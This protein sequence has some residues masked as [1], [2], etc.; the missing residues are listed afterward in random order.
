[1]LGDATSQIPAGYAVGRP[2]RDELARLPAIEV[3]AAAIFPAEDLAPAL[4]EDSDP[5]SF[6]EQAFSADRL[7]VARTLAPAAPVGFA[8]AILLDGQAHLQ[9]IDVLPEHARQGLG[10]ALVVQVIRWA[11]AM[12]YRF[13]TLTTFRHLAWNAPFY[14]SLGFVEVAEPELGP[15]LRQLLA[16][17]TSLGLD[18][19]KRIAMR[20]DLAIA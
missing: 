20:F 10:R 2:H 1:M 5:L 3:A 6:F 9:E 17:E 13:L 14:A 11:Q 7:W 16:E 18:P 15:Q 8:A 4:R 12:N 19:D